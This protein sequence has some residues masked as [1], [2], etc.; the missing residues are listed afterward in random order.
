MDDYYAAA[1]ASWY[2]PTGIYSVAAIYQ[3]IIELN[4]GLS[5]YQFDNVV[6]K[7]ADSGMWKGDASVKQQITFSASTRKKV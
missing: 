5:T 4:G 6:T 1:E 7:L 2:G 3:Y